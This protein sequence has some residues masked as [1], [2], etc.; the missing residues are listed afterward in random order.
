MSK[1]KFKRTEELQIQELSMQLESCKWKMSE[2]EKNEKAYLD[3]LSA[4]KIDLCKAKEDISTFNWKLDVAKEE[5]TNKIASIAKQNEAF[6]NHLEEQHK[7]AQEKSAEEMVKMKQRHEEE[8]QETKRH[9]ELYT[10]ELREHYEDDRKALEERNRELIY[11]WEIDQNEIEITSNDLIG[12]GGWGTVQKGKWRGIDVAVKKL[13]LDIVSRHNEQ[14]VRREIKLLSQA[15]HPN[16]LLFLGAVIKEKEGESSFIVTEL[17]DTDL[18]LAYRRDE[19]TEDSKIPILSDIA[20]ALIY[21]HSCR[22]PIMYAYTEMLAVLMSFLKL[23]AALGNGKPSYLTL[24][25][26]TS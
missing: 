14:L 17:L 9:Y 5:N 20:A 8:L 11:Q 26:P 7:D 13:H 24:E 12:S 19:I 2:L 15:R 3:E 6:I 23:L 22:V 10:K 21:L 16:I 18:R 1:S 4:T 25:L